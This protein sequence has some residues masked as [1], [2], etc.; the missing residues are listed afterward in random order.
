MFRSSVLA[1]YS[2]LAAAIIAAVSVPQLLG[3]NFLLP[4]QILLIL[5]I[6]GIFFFYIYRGLKPALLIFRKT[7]REISQNDPTL[8]EEDLRKIGNYSRSIFFNPKMLSQV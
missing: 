7:V 4:V 5:V 6:M 1:V 3:I 8:D 2:L